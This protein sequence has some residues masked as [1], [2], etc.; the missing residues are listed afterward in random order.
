MH[1]LKF[2]LLCHSFDDLTFQGCNRVVVLFPG[3][4][5]AVVLNMKNNDGDT[6]LHFLATNDKHL[7]EVKSLI[8]FGADFTSENNEVSIVIISEANQTITSYKLPK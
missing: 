2:H 1:N 8:Q 4:D 3:H 5:I 6:A 7:A